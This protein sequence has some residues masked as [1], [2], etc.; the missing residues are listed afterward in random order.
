[1]LLDPLI[2]CLDKHTVGVMALTASLRLALRA[3]LILI[4]PF[5]VGRV[6]GA[7]LSGFARLPCKYGGRPYPLVYPECIKCVTRDLHSKV[8]EI[9]TSINNFGD[10]YLNYGRVLFSHF[11]VNSD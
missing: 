2:G 9:G 10:Q 4:H 1:M 11:H 6:Y 5:T 3:G 7:V 8:D